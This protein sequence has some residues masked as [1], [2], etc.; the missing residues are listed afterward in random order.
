MFYN[1]DKKF[2]MVV[3]EFNGYWGEIK[4]ID[5]GVWF[6]SESWIWSGY[7]GKLIEVEVCFCYFCVWFFLN[8]LFVDECLVGYV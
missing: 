8:D 3:C 1:F 6:I 2:Y 5:W 7:E 4:V